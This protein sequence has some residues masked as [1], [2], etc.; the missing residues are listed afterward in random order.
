M[1]FAALPSLAPKAQATWRIVVKAA[2]AGDARF[3]V[4]MDDDWLGDIPVEETEATNQY[5]VG[6]GD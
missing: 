5:E 6:S 4:T 1:T 2:E 3:K